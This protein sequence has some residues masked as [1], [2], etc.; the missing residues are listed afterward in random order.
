MNLLVRA[1]EPRDL[2]AIVDLVGQLGYPSEERA[3]ADRLERLAADPRS[4]VYV[5]VDGSASWASLLS[6]GLAWAGLCW[7]GWRS[8]RGPRAATEST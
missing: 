4:W 1:V 5:A 6:R 8:G 3:V 7:I 2:A